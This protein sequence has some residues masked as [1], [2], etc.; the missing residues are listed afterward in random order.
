[1]RFVRAE[2]VQ[3]FAKCPSTSLYRRVIRVSVSSL[4]VA[5]RLVTTGASS[6]EVTVRRKDFEFGSDPSETVTS[7]VVEPNWL[8]AG[9]KERAQLVPD[10]DFVILFRGKSVR[11][12]EVTVIESVQLGDESISVNE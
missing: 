7:T 2:S 5:I 12:E 11:L 10:P 6:T 3:M 9:D 1:M 4:M 8:G